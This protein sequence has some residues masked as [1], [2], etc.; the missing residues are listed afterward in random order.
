M[1][2]QGASDSPRPEGLPQPPGRQDRPLDRSAWPLG[3]LLGLWTVLPGLL[4]ASWAS[5]GAPSCALGPLWACLACR[6]VLFG[7]L[8]DGSLAVQ[9]ARRARQIPERPKSTGR[10]ARRGPRGVQQTHEFEKNILQSFKSRE[11]RSPQAEH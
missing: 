3:R 1:F 11:T 2:C 4:D 6:P 10:R 9:R 5:P 7:R 8:L